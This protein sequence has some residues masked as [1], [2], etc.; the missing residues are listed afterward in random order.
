M[1]LIDNLN[2]TISIK[3]F[4]SYLR[5]IK[6]FEKFMIIFWFLGPLI[7]L[8]ERSPADIWVVFIVVVFLF[9]SLLTNDWSWIKIVWFKYAF[10]FWIV[11][12]VSAV[13]SPMPIFSFGEGFVWIRFPLYAVA[14]QSWLGANRDVRII[15]LYIIMTCMMLMSIILFLEVMIEPKSN[16]T[17]PYGDQIPGSYLAKFCLPAHCVIVSASVLYLNKKSVLSGFYILITLLASF[18]TGERNNMVL[19]ICSTAFAV[20]SYKFN[21]R[22]ILLWVFTLSI[23]LTLLYY[24]TEETYDLFYHFYRYFDRIPMFNFDN[25]YWGT[26][27]SGIQQ[28]FE[29]PI[30]GIGP[31]GTRYTCGYLEN[32]SWLPGQNYC[33]NHPH[34]I[35]IQIFAETGLIGGFFFILMIVQIFKS[36]W[37]AKKINSNCIMS[38]TAYIIPLAFFFPFQHAGSFFGQWNNLFIWFALGFVLSNHIIKK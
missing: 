8:T 24:L 36:C 4:I 37:I 33:G 31:S 13:L 9:R 26:W 20:F 1:N 5:S 11:S 17:W 28:W 7:Y 3:N 10:L 34:N 15:M 12:L 32:I 19:R 21:Y 16:L 25:T 23:C 6:R 29:T 14:I 22:V 27:R 18:L 35:F 2:L 38:C 30:F